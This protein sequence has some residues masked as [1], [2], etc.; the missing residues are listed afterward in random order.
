MYILDSPTTDGIVRFEV[1]G[2]AAL[3]GEVEVVS[4]AD[5]LRKLKSVMSDAVQTIQTVGQQITDGIEQMKS[6]PSELEVEFGVKVDGEVGAMI[7]TVGSGAHF[8]VKLK[9]TAN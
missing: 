5:G 8:S 6:K 7:A 4:P 2:A 9:W 3:E 1:T